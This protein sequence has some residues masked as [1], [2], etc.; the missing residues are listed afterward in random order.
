MPFVTRPL[1]VSRRAPP[2]LTFL[3]GSF[4][5]AFQMSEPGG[6]SALAIV[7]REIP[8]VG[9]GQVLI[10]AAFARMNFTDVLARR[11]APGTRRRGRSCRV[12]K[13]RGL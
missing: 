4:M 6:E 2:L 3:K 10:R 12:W 5:R 13:W 9:D 1:D 11:G 7:D 8:G